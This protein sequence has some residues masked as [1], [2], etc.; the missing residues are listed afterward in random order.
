MMPYKN[1]MSTI[2]LAVD[3]G[4]NGTKKIPEEIL[5]D[6][7]EHID[8]LEEQ[9]DQSDQMGRPIYLAEQMDQ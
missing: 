2:K 5:K 6:E 1:T 9:Q 8:W 4:D 3:V 7:E